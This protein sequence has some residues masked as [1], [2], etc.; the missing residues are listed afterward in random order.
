[1][2]FASRVALLSWQ[3]IS[4]LA[5]EHQTPSADTAGYRSCGPSADFQLDS[6]KPRHIISLAARIGIRES[7]PLGLARSSAAPAIRLHVD[8]A[9]SISRA[10][11]AKRCR[12]TLPDG[13]NPTSICETRIP[14]T[15]K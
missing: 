4:V 3:R 14:A 11:L 2:A 13:I 7:S 9:P 5:H 12:R 10:P 8:E 6:L 15:D 1:L